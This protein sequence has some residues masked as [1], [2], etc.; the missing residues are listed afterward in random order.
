MI[1]VEQG[2]PSNVVI[3]EATGNVT[4]DDYEGVLIPAVQAAAAT[5]DKIRLLYHL[6]P[7]FDGYEAS[8][9]LDDAKMGLRHWTG[10]E[11]IALVT[12][13]ESYRV[14]AKAFGF[15]MPG[16]VRVF[17]SSEL[18]DARSWVLTD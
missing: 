10:F 1:Q 8:A 2:H 15:V 5:G 7:S 17:A 12:D 4:G 3:A 11:R 16:H 13:H 18:D 9:A 6:G 14:L